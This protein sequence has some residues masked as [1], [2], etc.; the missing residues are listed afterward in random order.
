MMFAL[1][2]LLKLAHQTTNQVTQ[3]PENANL[4]ASYPCPDH[5]PKY[6]P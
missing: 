6:R 3:A 2:P 4:K 1:E 5:Q